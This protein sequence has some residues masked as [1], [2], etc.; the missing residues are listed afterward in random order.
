MTTSTFRAEFNAWLDEALGQDIPSSV[1]AFS[2]NLAEPWCIEIIG[3]DQFD[4]AD[5]DWACE[6]TSGPQ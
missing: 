6:E 1:V 3:A 4:P 2:L 5:P